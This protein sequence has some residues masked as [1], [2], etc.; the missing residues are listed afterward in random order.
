MKIGIITPTASRPYMVRHAALQ[1]VNQTRKPDIVCFHHNGRENVKS[2]EHFVKDVQGLNYYWLHTPYDVSVDERYSIPLEF[3]IGQNCDYYFYCD[4]DDIYYNH[5]IQET[6]DVIQ[7]QKCDLIIRNKCDWVKFKYEPWQ[8]FW[9]FAVDQNFTAHHIG[10][11][12]SM[13]FN[14]QFAVAWLKDLIKNT[15]TLNAGK[16]FYQ[17]ADL[18]LHKETAVNYKTYVYDK[19]SMCYVIHKGS[20]QSSSWV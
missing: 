16:E 14:K 10:V 3:L 5:H 17:H 18:L 12:S 19:T 4:D 2:Y 8:S 9:D 15:E 1:F 13:A 20:T 7:E 11:S 6:I